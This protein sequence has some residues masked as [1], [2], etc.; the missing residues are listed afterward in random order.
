MHKPGILTGFVRVALLWVMLA[1]APSVAALTLPTAVTAQ[2]PDNALTDADYQT[3]DKLAA[4]VEQ[5]VSTGEANDQR[6]TDLRTQI[7]DWRSRFQSGQGANASRIATVRDQINT[8]GPAPAEGATEDPDVAARRK[9]LTDELNTLQAPGVRSVEAAS[10]ATGIIQSIDQ[11]MR[12]RQTSALLQQSPTPLLPSSWADA[13]KQGSQAVVGL[14]QEPLNR[15]HDVTPSDFR[16]RGVRVIAFLAA[17]LFLLIYGRRWISSLPSRLSRSATDHS[18]DAVAFLVSLGQIAIP[19]IGVYLFVQAL[20]GSGLFADWWRPIL[21]ALPLAALTLFGGHWLAARLF[22]P[23]DDAILTMPEDCLQRCRI[24]G[25]GLAATL[26]AHMI[27]ANLIPALSGRPGAGA[28]SQFPVRFDEASAAV[29][30]LPLIV[31]AAFLL[32]KMGT[33]LRKATRFDGSDQPAYRV[34]VAA[35]MGAFI[36]PVAILIV[37]AA[38]GGYVSLANGIVWPLTRSIGL[39]ALIVLLQQFIAALYGMAMRDPKLGR[40]ALV[41]VLIGFALVLASIPLFALIWGA[42]VSDLAEAWT[43]MRQGVSLGG[44]RLSPGAILTFLVVFGIGYSVTRFVQGAFRGSILP[45]TKLDSGAQNA[46]VSGLGYIGIALATVLAI[47]SAGINL[48]SLAIVAGALSVG[49]GFGMQNIVSNFVSGIILLIERPISVGDW[50]KTGTSE[51]VVKS[52]SVR[53]TR[54]QTFDRTNIIIPNSDLIS[55]SVTNW[56]R[57]SLQGRVIVP[58]TVSYGS[59]TRKVSKIL[60][61]IAEDQPT[62]LIAPPPVV[63]FVDIAASGLQFQ[64]R[65]IISDINQGGD[66]QTQIR[67]QIIERFAKE[68]ISIPFAART[69]YDINMLNPVDAEGAPVPQPTDDTGPAPMA[70]KADPAAPDG[71]ITSGAEGVSGIGDTDGGEGDSRDGDGGSNS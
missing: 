5:I 10:R 13:A 60:T 35:G 58:I 43:A 12:D 56:T 22:A 64:L 46:V 1:L 55:Q 47:T 2:E 6:L 38:L 31:I 53:S 54:V 21:Q 71:T 9:A 28:T 67:H 50:I 14:V 7:V 57:G 62:V 18:R 17:A 69:T 11:L 34:R 36:R 3:W 48:S 19:V 42:R 66:V 24:Y 40:D 15:A 37:L 30:H 32:F 29:L 49:I 20:D 45:K 51:G 68:G 61:E 44:V 8:L 4:Q 63:A 39:F 59:D 70:S 27:V 23:D 65:A 16:E 52:I 33:I 26:A 41:P 25:S